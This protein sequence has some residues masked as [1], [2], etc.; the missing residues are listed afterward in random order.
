MADPHDLHLAKV[1]WE[2]AKSAVLALEAGDALIDE[3]KRR[4]LIDELR[5]ATDEYLDAL[6]RRSRNS[7]RRPQPDGGESS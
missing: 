6:L 3:K 2:R 4:D 7:K 5:R 1:R